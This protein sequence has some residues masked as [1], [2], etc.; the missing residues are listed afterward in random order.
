MKVRLNL[1]APLAGIQ[2][3]SI[4]QA[5]ERVGRFGADGRIVQ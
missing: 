3:D 4:D 5:A 1:S 2:H